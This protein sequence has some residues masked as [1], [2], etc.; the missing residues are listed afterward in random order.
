KSCR[1]RARSSQTLLQNLWQS[2]IDSS[3]NTCHAPALNKIARYVTGKADIF[4]TP[5]KIVRNAQ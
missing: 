1:V 2:E 3:L 4:L 5:G